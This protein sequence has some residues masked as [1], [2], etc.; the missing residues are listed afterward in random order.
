M[1]L[2]DVLDAV[3]LILSLILS[4]LGRVAAVENGTI[5]GKFWHICKLLGISGLLFGRCGCGRCVCNLL[6]YGGT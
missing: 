2:E 6:G 3:D 1:L 5:R 4:K